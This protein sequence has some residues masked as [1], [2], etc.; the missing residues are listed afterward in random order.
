MYAAIWSLCSN[1]AYLVRDNATENVIKTFTIPQN[2]EGID[3]T[4]RILLLKRLI[5]SKELFDLET[6]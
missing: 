6:T 4:D 3:T 1:A 5:S 2:E